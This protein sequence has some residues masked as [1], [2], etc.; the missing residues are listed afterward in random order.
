VTGGSTAAVDVLWK[1]IELRAEALPGLPGT[2]TATTGRSPWW[3]LAAAVAVAVL[4]GVAVWILA[5][6]QRRKAVGVEP[7]DQGAAD[8]TADDAWDDDGLRKLEEHAAAYA[9]GH[10]EAETYT[11]RPRF[12]FS[13]RD[14]LL[15]GPFVAWAPVD[16]A[17]R[18]RLV[19]SWDE[20]CERLPK[21]FEG[22][23]RNGRRN[24][25][26]LYRNGSGKPQARRYRDGER[27]Q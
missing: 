5:V 16:K 24:G 8:L 6:L 18:K 7:M 3:V 4:A 11:E 9:A 14:G 21:R 25:V 13:L 17:A 15:H 27:V 12:A 19:A 1:D 10:P 22:G 26:F 20:L 23:Y 2:S